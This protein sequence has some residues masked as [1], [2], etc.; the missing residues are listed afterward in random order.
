MSNLRIVFDASTLIS[1]VSVSFINSLKI[2]AEK[3]NFEFYISNVVYNECVGRPLK[4][5]KYELSAVRLDYAIKQG[6][7]KLFEKNLN[8][9]TKRIQKIAN[10]IFIMNDKPLELVHSGEAE[11]LA[12]LNILPAKIFAIDERTTRMIIENPE[13]LAGRLSRKYQSEIKINKKAL[14]EFNSLV[15]PINIIRSAEFIALFFEHD[16]LNIPK[17]KKSL[18]AALYAVKYSGCAISSKEIDGFVESV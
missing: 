2:L 7:I 14:R 1:L 4:I 15:G 10:R 11:S 17:N 12:L 5:K 9:E 8:K 6:W 3:L 16:L 13:D 18:E